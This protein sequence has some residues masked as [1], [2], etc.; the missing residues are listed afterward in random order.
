MKIAVSWSSGKDSAMALE[1]VLRGGEFT[2]VGLLTTI[3]ESYMR[4]SKHGVRE[5]LVEEQARSIGL[6]LFKTYIPP[7][8][9]NEVYEQV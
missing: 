1:H 8:C 3:T 4:V 2:V 9:S 7:N 5:S 6:Q